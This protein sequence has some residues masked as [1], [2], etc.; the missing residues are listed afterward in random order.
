MAISSAHT[1]STI[2]GC[3]GSSGGRSDLLAGFILPGIG[4]G[5]SGRTCRSSA[6]RGSIPCR[7]TTITAACLAR[8]CFGRPGLPIMNDILPIHHVD[9]VIDQRLR[10]CPVGRHLPQAAYRALDTGLVAASVLLCS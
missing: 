6:R 2:A 1:G 9:A 10:C 3:I 7:R 4:S 5:R 8:F